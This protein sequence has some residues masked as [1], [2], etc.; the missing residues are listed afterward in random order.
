V[1]AEIIPLTGS[2]ASAKGS[3]REIS[4]AGQLQAEISHRILMRY[5]PGITAAM[6]IAYENRVFNIRSVVITGE[7]R[8]TLEILAQEGVAA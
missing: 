8:E 6:R 3:G 5:Q 1:W 4:F 2:G 7:N